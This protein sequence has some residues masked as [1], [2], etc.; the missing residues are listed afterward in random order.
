MRI[1]KKTEAI[2]CVLNNCIFKT[3]YLKKQRIFHPF[4]RF[5]YLQIYHNVL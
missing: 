5:V 1:V 4:T 3:L 2:Q